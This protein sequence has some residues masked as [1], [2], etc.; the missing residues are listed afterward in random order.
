MKE[1]GIISIK[2]KAFGRLRLWLIFLCAILPQSN[3]LATEFVQNGRVSPAQKTVRLKGKVLDE[4]KHALP[5]VSVRM[6]DTPVMKDFPIM[7]GT[8]TDN[9]GRFTLK[10]PVAEGRLEFSF[11]GFSSQVVDFNEKSQKDP[12]IVILKEK[13]H[14]MDEV[15]VNGYQE[16]NSKAMTGAY[17]KVNMDDLIMTGSETLENML[18]GQVPGMVVTNPN[19]LTGT[20]QK[21]RVRGTSTLMG[22]AEPLW[23]VDGIIQEDPLPVES[24]SLATMDDNAD[25]MKDYIGSAISW[26]NPND[27]ESITVLKDAVATAM[28]GVRAANGVIVI[29]TKKGEKGRLSVN[30]SGDFTVG[31][32]MDY[33]RQNVMNSKERVALSREGWERGAVMP[34]EPVGY[35]ALA[36][37]YYVDR[38]IGYDEFNERVKRLETVNTDWFDI[39]YQTPFSQSHNVSFSGG[40]DNATYYASLGY[41]NVQNTAKGNWQEQYT[42]SLRLGLTFGEKLDIQTTLSGARSKTNAFASGVNPYNYALETSRVIDCYDESSPDGYY[43]YE[44]ENNY[45]YN[46]LNELDHSGNE[47]VTHSL[48]LNLSARWRPVDSFSLTLTAGGGTSNTSAR[49]WFTE[50]TNYIAT[51]RGME[52][53]DREGND[54]SS[55]RLPYGG[56]L[57]TNDTRGYNYT[58]RFQPEFMHTFGG[59]H[60]VNLMGGVEIRSVSSKGQAQKTWGYMP[61]RGETF[62]DV[63]QTVNGKDNTLRPSTT[64]SRSK[65][66]SLGYY[67]SLN[68]MYDN[69]YSAS[70][71]VRGDGTNAFGKEGNFLPVWTFGLRWNV[72]DERWMANQNIISNL[73]ISSNIGYQGNVAPSVSPKLVARIGKL[74]YQTG[75]FEMTWAELPKPDLR[76]EKTLSVNVGVNFGLFDNKINGVFSWYYRKT[77]DLITNKEVPYE[78]GT[79]SMYMN[80]GD[81]RNRGWDL[82]LSFVPVRTKDFVWSLSTS[83]SGNNNKVNSRVEEKGDWKDAVSGKM[84]K[85]GYPVGAFWAFRFTGLNPRNGG[86]EFDLSRTNSS[87]AAVDASEY[88]VYMG[89]RE[90]TFT[91]GINSTLR[92][93]RFSIPLQF[94]ISRGNYEFLASP[95]TSYTQMPSEYKNVS[96]DLN[97]RWRKPGDELFTNIPSIPTGE[98]S[99]SIPMMWGDGKTTSVY[100]LEAWQYSDVRVVNAWYIRFQDFRFAYDLPEKWIQSFAKSVRVAVTVANPLIIKSKDFKGK[101]P[102]VALGNQPRAENYSLSVSASF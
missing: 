72:S 15:V 54:I 76:W 37:A 3:V 26:L 53:E 22:N 70:V 2:R 77:K 62:V 9:Q 92:W 90:P 94:Y 55:S 40:G 85:K 35:N 89:T 27:I 7:M 57:Q 31:R 8:A 63:P 46:I 68:Y 73:G 71:S 49:T 69:R 87:A 97:N 21:V 39:L 4:R 42:G 38:T 88:M 5:G 101:D 23:V 33:K 17:T 58:L 19:G 34:R 45:K 14:G 28:Y 24:S 16:I 30:Y 51:Y 84:N 47:N 64:I 50:H 6:K 96:A 86:P 99:N 83:F 100:P 13:S 20:R 59:V 56:L 81:M 29:K 98:N 95:Y 65:D 18:Q 52:L 93:K 44:R 48:N 43:Y 1:D 12:I 10:L 11:I 80:S 60:Y 61:E 32:P 102:E 36:Y 82:A 79:T 78:N 91:L 74:N 41:R 25:M 66:N 75:E 67:A